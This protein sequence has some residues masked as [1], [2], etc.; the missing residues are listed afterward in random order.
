MLWKFNK[1]LNK[2]LSSL[3]LTFASLIAELKFSLILSLNATLIPLP[4]PPADAL[5][6]TEI[7]LASFKALSKPTTVS[8]PPGTSETPADF[9]IFLIQ[10]YHPWKKWHQKEVQ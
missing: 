1:L 6:I 4:P 7:N 8:R 2:N 9:A 10:F 3:K 5:I